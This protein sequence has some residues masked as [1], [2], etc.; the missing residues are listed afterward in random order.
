MIVDLFLVYQFA[1]RL[2]LPFDQWDAFKRGVIDKNGDILVPADKRTQYQKDSFQVFDVM[3][4][5][6]KQTLA[7]LPGGQSALAR[8]GSL[9]YLLKEEITTP[10]QINEEDLKRYI[11]MVMEDEGGGNVV[12]GGAIAGVGV[13]NPNLPNQA[14][15]GVGK[16][17]KS[18][19]QMLNRKESVPVDLKKIRKVL[20]LVNINVG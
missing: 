7:Y 4:R 18:K 13:P 8:W 14:E 1:K 6:I 12:G 15:P 17:A 19:Y 9:F 11:A 2:V 3:V 16:K 20:G 10:E 5:N